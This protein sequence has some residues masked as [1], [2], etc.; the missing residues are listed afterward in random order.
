[1]KEGFKNFEQAL[2]GPQLLKSAVEKSRGITETYSPDMKPLR[3][4]Q[5]T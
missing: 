1:M 5:S 3:R 4:L 2:I